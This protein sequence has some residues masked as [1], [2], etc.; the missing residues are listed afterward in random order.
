MDFLTLSFYAFLTALATGLGALPFFFKE[1]FSPRGLSIGYALA[2]GFMLSASFSLFY[3]GFIVHLPSLIGGAL[4]G[5]GFMYFLKKGIEEKYFPHQEIGEVILQ[6]KYLS[7]SILLVV[8]MTL[9]SFA[10]GIGIGISFVKGEDFGAYITIAIAVHNIPEGLA[11]SL[12]MRQ[13]GL[14]PWYGFFWSIFSSLPQPLMAFPTYF[15]VEIFR[16]LFPIGLGFAGSAMLYIVV[17]ELFEEARENLS[18]GEFLFF[19]VSSSF[20]MGA[21][22]FFLA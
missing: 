15:V 22:Q 10:E 16:V 11:I 21:F 17:F 14:S 7:S 5:M 19:F 1:S 9:H 8:A 2:M 12:V 18:W 6:R 20:I 13:A 4:L 3:E